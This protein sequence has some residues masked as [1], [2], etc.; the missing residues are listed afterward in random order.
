M[1]LADLHRSIALGGAV[2]MQVTSDR[3]PGDRR[4]HV[5]AVGT[6]R[7]WP[8]SGCA[9]SS[10]ARASSIDELVDD[11]EEWIDVE[12][13]RAPHAAPTPSGPGCASLIVGLNPGLLSADVG[14]GFARPGNRFW[15][16]ALASGLVTRTLD[17]FHALRV[18]R[19][20]MTNIVRRAHGC[21][22]TS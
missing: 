14:V 19:V 15:P 5:P 1:A 8:P 4:R 9:T 6:S 7:W 3:T 16:A 21:A 2:H 20:G 13:T 10:R 22:P 11:G 17:P 18:D 12:A